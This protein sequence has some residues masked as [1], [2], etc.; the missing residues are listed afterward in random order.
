MVADTCPAW[1][2]RPG[3][4]SPRPR[5]SIQASPIRRP[6]GRL[7]LQ[8]RPCPRN[9]PGNRPR[10]DSPASER[11]P[12]STRREHNRFQD[13]RRA[14][15][16]APGPRRSPGGPGPD[17]SR[18]GTARPGHGHPGRPGRGAGRPNLDP[19]DASPGCG[20]STAHARLRG[21]TEFLVSPRLLKN[22]PGCRRRSRRPALAAPRSSILDRVPALCLVDWAV[23]PHQGP[24]G[25]RLAGVANA[26]LRRWP[27]RPPGSGHGRLPHP[28]TDTA[29]VWSRHYSMPG[30]DR[31]SVAKGIRERRRP[32][33]RFLAAQ[34]AVPPWGCG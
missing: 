34:A 31:G 27:T 19:L 22:P 18:P 30:L 26:V 5:P 14:R 7:T 21:R 2:R 24:V 10:H 13:Q 4:K 3:G 33:E 12:P 15:S 1:G 11:H 8:P 23:F 28:R 16:P 9:R 25:A 17:P 32:R 20:W 6:P 29:T